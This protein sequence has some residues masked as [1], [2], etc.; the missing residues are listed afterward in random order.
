MITPAPGEREDSADEDEAP[1]AQEAL[2]TTSAH[3]TV[4]PASQD[5]TGL[6]SEAGPA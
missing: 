3:E 6:E 5:G 4:G 1:E 2:D